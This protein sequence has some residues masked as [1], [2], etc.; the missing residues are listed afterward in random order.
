MSLKT[1]P[2]E[3]LAEGA[4]LEVENLVA[5]AIEPLQILAPDGTHD[6]M[7]EPDLSDEELLRFYDFM[8]LT[9][10]FDTRGLRLQRQGRTG[11]Y[12][13]CTGEEALQIGSAAALAAQDW[14]YCAYREPGAALWRGMPL[15]KM[16]CQLYGNA[17]DPIKGRQMPSHFGDRDAKFVPA[18][19][20]VGTQIPMCVGSA[21]AAKIKKE[22]AV[23]LTYFGDGATSEGDFHVGM[24]FAGVYKLPVVFF[25]KNNQYAI[26]CPASQQTA[27]HT[28]ALKAVAYGFEGVRV[29]G[30][31]VLAVYKVTKEAVDKARSGGGPTLIE[32]VTFRMGPHSTA[33]DPRRYRTEKGVEEWKAK[34]P[35]LRFRL[36]LERKGLWDEA[37]EK[38]LQERTMKEVDD[39]IRAAEKVPP[40][41]IETIF[42]DVYAEM[43]W[44]L[45]EQMEEAKERKTRAMVESAPTWGRNHHQQ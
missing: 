27:S 30:N 43:P 1:M 18:S 11:F 15:Y 37:K 6:P 26:S 31:D 38:A 28:F 14:I 24:N 8:M 44:H 45:E 23:F 29:D 12:V 9:R 33:D 17:D 16:L 39:T 10:E 5:R 4:R 21:W 13:P 41:R 19:S 35:L 32:A 20:P 22:N 40:P 2:K 42:E 3:S 34:D 7:L 25:C 36:Y